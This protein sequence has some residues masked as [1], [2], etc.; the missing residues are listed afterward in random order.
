MLDGDSRPQATRGTVDPLYRVGS[1]GTYSARLADPTGKE[2][3]LF[4]LFYGLKGTA[5]VRPES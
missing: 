4:K 3:L 5:Q 1:V 2:Q